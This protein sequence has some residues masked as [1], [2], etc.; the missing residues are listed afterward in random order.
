MISLFIRALLLLSL[1]TAV[2]AQP[3]GGMPEG[4]PPGPPPAGAGDP[5]P[6]FLEK[7]AALDAESTPP[8]DA[9]LVAG[10]SI[11]EAWTDVADHMA[12][13]PAFN[14]AIGGS[15]TANILEHADAL[16]LQYKPAVVVL[17]AG[18]NDLSEGVSRGDVE[19]NLT[20]LVAVINN[21]LPETRIV[22]AGVIKSH[23]APQNWEIIDG[24][25]ATLQA[26]AANNA[27]L[28]YI[29]LSPVL[30]D[31]SGELLPGM[32]QKDGLHLEAAAYAEFAK[33]IKPI[34][35]AALK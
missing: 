34:I 33:H 1:S 25:N 30:Y 10:S 27:S 20:R 26:L 6:G 14:R 29:D 22:Y 31:E 24:A 23:V 3:P 7:F 11:F 8:E 32:V 16:I 9:I 13:L 21:A 17:Y 28:D 19:S 4:M 18:I 35:D 15:K 5:F 12:P 2:F